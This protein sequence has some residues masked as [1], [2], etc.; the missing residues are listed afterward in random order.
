MRRRR[1]EGIIDGYVSIECQR[2]FSCAERSL[3]GGGGGGTREKQNNTHRLALQGLW[4]DGLRR[5]RDCDGSPV[6]LVAV[7]WGRG[8]RLEGI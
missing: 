4:G 7:M 5:D 8:V 6:S 1:E 3:E 2:W